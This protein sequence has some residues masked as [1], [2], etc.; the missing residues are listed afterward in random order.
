[1][2]TIEAKQQ[3]DNLS[4]AWV[5][6]QK[7]FD[8][9]PHQW[10]HDMLKA[11]RAPKAIC[12]LL[13]HVIPMWTTTFTVN[14]GEDKLCFEIEL[15]R[16]IFQGDSLSPLL[17]CLAIAPLSMLLGQQGGYRCAYLMEPLT[18]LFFM[19]D[20][21]IYGG[22]PAQ[23][24]QIL[25][26]V[27]EGSAAVGMALGL[28]K[29]G[30]AHMIKGKVVQHGNSM[31]LDEG[32]VAEVTVETAYKYLGIDQLFSPNHYVIRQRLKQ[33]FLD[34]LDQIWSSFLSGK[35]KVM[36]TNVW[37]TSL[38]RYYLTTISWPITELKSVDQK[39]GR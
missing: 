15:K 3:K 12:H 2:I 28:Q 17:F 32:E 37:G 39:A 1:M 25:A 23:L 35:N 26:L 5:D 18:H 31:A 24:D 14:A 34:R 30:V 19:D 33:K 11:I 6:Y 36:A 27:Q 16:G 22:G 21:K 38:F 4:V 8:R 29:C 13:K 10:L 20:L 9:V 7:A